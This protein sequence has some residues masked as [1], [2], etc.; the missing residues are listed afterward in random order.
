MPSSYVTNLMTS[1]QLASLER[2]TSIA[3]VNVQIPPNLNF[4]GASF[5]HLHNL[6][7]YLGWSSLHLCHALLLDITLTS[8]SGLNAIIL[9]FFL[10]HR[11]RLVVP[12]PLALPGWHHTA[13][14]DGTSL[15]LSRIIVRWDERSALISSNTTCWYYAPPS[16]LECR[17]K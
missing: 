14:Q 8:V 12:R 4:G 6:P 3:E 10:F 17:T 16:H 13:N 1:S 7:I 5:S 11:Q 15:W 9:Q 2:C